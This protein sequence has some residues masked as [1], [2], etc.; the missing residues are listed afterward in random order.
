MKRIEPGN[1]K[2]GWIGTGVMGQS[3]ASHL[4]QAG[5]GVTIYSRTRDK[6]DVLLDQGAQWA[7]SPAAVAMAS[8]VTFAMVGLPQDV[9]QVFLDNDGILAG[10]Q[11][12]QIVVDMT[13]SRPELAVEIYQQAKQRQVHSIDAPVSGGD[14]GARNGSLSIMIGGD[15]EPVDALQACWQ[16]MG[17]TIV[18]QGGPGAGQH[19]K[20][21]NQILV[22][23]GMIGICESLLYA[24]R[25][26][27][28]LESVLE[29][30]S[31][32]AA[33]SWGLSNLAPRIINNQFGPGFYVDHFVKD[34]GIALEEADRLKLDLQGLTLAR[35]LYLAMQQQGMGKLGTH[36]LQKFLAGQSGIH[37]ESRKP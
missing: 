4:I 36:A 18:H 22:A 7:D 37:W 8:D 33:G 5:F 34:L 13:T 15:R 31:S 23:A 24:Y 3:M 2:I 6:A 16:A 27:L 19:T 20:M 26:G 1:A 28:D 21:A 11:P 10:C 35:D 12:G 25:S 9:R 29:S 14:I 32:G 30:V 17:K